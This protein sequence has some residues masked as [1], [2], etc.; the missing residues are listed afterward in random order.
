MRKIRV[1]ATRE[2]LTAVR[3]R[4]FVVSLL[5]LPVMVGASALLGKFLDTLVDVEEKTFA[6]VDRSPGG[7]LAP[8]LVNAVEERNRKDVYD[9]KTG[10]Q[11]K[12]IF[13]VEVVSASANT[14]EAVDQLRVELSERMRRGELFGVLEIG[15]DVYSTELLP[16]PDPDA[17]PDPKRERRWIRYQTNRPTLDDFLQLAASVLRPAIGERRAVQEGLTRDLAKRLLQPTPVVRRGL[18]SRQAATGAAVDA[19]EQ[20]RLAPMLVPAGL[21][22]LMLMG[23][24]MGATPLM[25][26]VVEEKMQKIAEVLLGSVRPF[27][28]M[29]GKLL[30]MAGVSLTIA[31]IYLT[32]AVLMAFRYDIS[33]YLTPSVLAWYVVYQVL[34]V[35]LYGSLFISIGAACTNMKETQNLLWPVLLLATLPLFVLFHLLREP[36]HPVVT[37]LSFFPFSTPLLMIARQTVPPGIPWWQPALGVVVVTATT[38]LC[39]YA[40]GRIFRLG[41]LAQGRGAKLS[42]IVRWVVRG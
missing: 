29:L 6:V 42:E 24:L 30:G 18:T 15:P 32:A 10:E 33:E 3:T 9:S 23:M 27:E 12:P 35:L 37:A 20:G 5:L 11:T 13:H 14:P 16:R 36:N 34:V 2:Y 7:E 8:L 28:L 1:I 31:A 21:M 25:Q 38:L 22:L 41:L 26:G 19:S 39:V 17:P 40:A 4:A